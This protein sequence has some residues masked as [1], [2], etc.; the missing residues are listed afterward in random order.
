MP[1]YGLVFYHLS[2]C[3]RTEGNVVSV[4]LPILRCPCC[5]RDGRLETTPDR[6]IKMCPGV[7]EEM[8]EEFR[9]R[10]YADW[11]I[12]VDPPPFREPTTLYGIPVEPL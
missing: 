7:W 9:R 6:A 12:V 8:K 1:S 3:L 5:K 4:P 2:K 10:H 11:A